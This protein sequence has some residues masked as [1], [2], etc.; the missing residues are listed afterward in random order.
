[1]PIF[2]TVYTM[3]KDIM[4]KSEIFTRST[5]RT[6]ADKEEAASDAR[7]LAERSCPDAYVWMYLVEEVEPDVLR[8]LLTANEAYPAPPTPI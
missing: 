2:H 6:A 7:V 3:R 5:L 4:G 1:M 8:D